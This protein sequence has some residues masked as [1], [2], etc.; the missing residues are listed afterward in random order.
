MRKLLLIL[1]CLCAPAL[2]DVLPPQAADMAERYRSN[3]KAFDRTDAWCEGR[4]VAAACIIPG[5]A[6]EGGGVGTCEREIHRSDFKIDLLCSLQAPP[7]IDRAIPEGPWRADTQW[8]EQAAV[9]E[10]SAQAINGQGLVCSEP[11]IVSDRF[12][13]GLKPTQTCE[14][15]VSMNGSAA[16]FKGVCTEQKQS[17]GIYYQGRRTLTRPVL[18]CEPEQ[19]LPSPVLKP[20]SAWRKL[21]Q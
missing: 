2:G 17:R 21:L 9:H 20:V 14:A 10:P 12:C 15:E 16:R 8:C 5:N 6:F 4:G 3:P 7:R 13:V 19:R 11:Q 1:V 18:T